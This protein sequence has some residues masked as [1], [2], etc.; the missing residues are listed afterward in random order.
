MPNE[1]KLTAGQEAALS[2]IKAAVK[3]P[4]TRAVDSSD[5]C[6]KYQSIRKDLLTLIKILKLIPKF[7]AKAAAAIEF[8]MSLAD[9]LC[10]A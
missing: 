10:P 9:K 1:V 4:Q 7:G 5:L 6:K 8:L 2:R 3:G